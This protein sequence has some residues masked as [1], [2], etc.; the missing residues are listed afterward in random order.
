MTGWGLGEESWSI[1]IAAFE[2]DPAS[3][4]VWS[5]LDQFLKAP[6][7]H[8]LG[9]DLYIAGAC[10]DSGGHNAQDVYRFVRERSGRD[11]WAIKGDQRR[12]R[13]ELVADLAERN[14]RAI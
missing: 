1:A 8:A 3:P 11:I 2:G 5:Q 12:P 4:Q 13:R 14:A 6:Y 7:K 10:I 9:F